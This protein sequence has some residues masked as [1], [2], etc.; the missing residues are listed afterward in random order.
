MIFVYLFALVEMSY[1]DICVAQKVQV[2]TEV[3]MN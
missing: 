2:Y 1:A 3:A